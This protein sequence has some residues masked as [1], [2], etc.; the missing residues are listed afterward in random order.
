MRAAV[1]SKKGEPF[2]IEVVP[3]PAPGEG[4]V[5]LRVSR[6]GICGSDVHM[7][8]KDGYGFPAGSVL[9]HEFCGEVVALGKD[10]GAIRV[11]DRVTAMP[12]F[13]CGR[14]ASCLRGEPGWCANSGR[15]AG[16][17]SAQGGYAQYMTVAARSSVVL[18]GG[19][20]D[21]L[22]ALVEPLAVALHGVRR[23]VIGPE[24]RVAVLGAGPIGLGAAFWARQAGAKAVAVIA[25][26]RRNAAL[27]A[28]LGAGAFLTDT[29]GLDDA[30]GGAP[31]VVFECVGI[32][33]MLGQSV[34][35]AAPRAQ[36]IVLGFCTHPDAINGA[37]CL[38]KEITIAYSKTYTLDDYTTVVRTLEAGA[39]A[40]AAMV[41]RIE[42]LARLPALIEAMRAGLPDCKIQIDPWA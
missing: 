26:S 22:G 35:I 23:A 7:T 1:F 31:N 37:A 6:C 21:E 30:L 32:A 9:G 19:I 38:L 12:F 2:H 28:Q 17:G 41:S 42:K 33:G 25:R 8:A 14:C 27:A 3:D 10:A 36:V 24:T 29:A 11:G 39:Q 15:A 5:V 4:E 18:P 40:P 34:K 13:G 20:S 16:F